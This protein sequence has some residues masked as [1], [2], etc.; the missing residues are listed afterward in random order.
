MRRF[1]F[2]G[3]RKRMPLQPAGGRLISLARAEERRA[4]GL[5]YGSRRQVRLPRAHQ[6]LI[7]LDDRPGLAGLCGAA[8]G[9]QGRGV[10]GRAFVVGQAEGDEMVL[11]A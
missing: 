9:H 1:G 3:L 5:V 6:K 11:F 4:Q 10:I 7:T 8:A 2:A